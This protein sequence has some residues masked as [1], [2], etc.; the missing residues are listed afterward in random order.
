MDQP[1][2]FDSG[3]KYARYSFLVGYILAQEDEKPAWNPGDFFDDHYGKKARNV[4]GIERLISV[5]AY[6]DR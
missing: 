4:R 2:D 1:F 3:A 6:R 5:S